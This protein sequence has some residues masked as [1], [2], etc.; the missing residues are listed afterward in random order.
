[1]S[2]PKISMFTGPL[3]DGGKNSTTLL[4]RMIQPFLYRFV[5]PC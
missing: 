4:E 3:V 5:T 2:F 1:M